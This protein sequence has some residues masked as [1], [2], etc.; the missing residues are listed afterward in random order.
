MVDIVHIQEA[1]PV[2]AHSPEPLILGLQ[3]VGDRGTAAQAADGGGSTSKLSKEF[4]SSFVLAGAFTAL[5]DLNGTDLTKAGAW[6]PKN[7]EQQ[8]FADQLPAAAR[9]LPSLPSA[10]KVSGAASVGDPTPVNDF[11]K[12]QGMDIQLQRGDKN[13]LFVAGTESIEGSWKAKAQTLQMDDGKDHPS[14]YK[15]GKVHDVNNQQVAEI[16]S[17]PDMKVYAI[18]LPADK[19]NMSG[20]DVQ[21]YAQSIVGKIAAQETAGLDGKPGKVEF[22]MTDLN[23]KQEL[24]GLIGLQS[25]DKTIQV[26]QAKMQTQ[27]QMD[28]FGFKAKQ[29]AAVGMTR[30][31]E[32]NPPAFQVKGQFIFAVATPAGQLALATQVDYADMKRPPKTN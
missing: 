14:I 32:F 24:T 5:K 11:L 21:K 25:K 2:P 26:A 7:P 1:P 31:I 8:Y 28:E 20:V 6:N 3:K 13:S 9:D 30:G 4:P 23:S 17:T 22:P 18:P 29:A 27:L 12:K 15:D 16:Q 19:Q 10:I